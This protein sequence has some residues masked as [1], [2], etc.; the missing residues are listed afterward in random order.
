MAQASILYSGTPDQSV[1]LH[2]GTNS[3][4][5]SFD[6]DVVLFDE[7]LQEKHFSIILND[8]S[9]TL[10]LSEGAELVVLDDSGNNVPFQANQPLTLLSFHRLV[11][12]NTE[13]TL[14]DLPVATVPEPAIMESPKARPSVKTRSTGAL[15]FVAVLVASVVLLASNA[16]SNTGG[17]PEVMTPRLPEV[18]PSPSEMTLEDVRKTLMAAGFAP[19]QLQTDETGYQASFYVATESEQAKLRACLDA[20]EAKISAKIFVDASILD[21]ATL[22]LS[23]TEPN[24]PEMT[25]KAGELVISGAPVES[26]WRDDVTATLRRDIPG[27]RMVSFS[28]R[29][30]AWKAMIDDNLAAVWSGEN[31]Y[32]VLTDGRKIRKGQRI[33]DDTVFQGISGDSIL[34]VTVNETNEEY[35]LK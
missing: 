33:T 16:N 21:A 32:I 29:S 20:I 27:L 8:D 13:I 14:E 4:G 15:G 30:E 6:N 25:V 3:F 35:K 5:T 10:V 28:G 9:A 17:L 31:P 22:V 24:V 12:A 1:R 26:K 34:M 2:P 18:Q 19:D 23:L 7:A 11:A